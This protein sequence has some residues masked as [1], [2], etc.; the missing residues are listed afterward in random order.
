MLWAIIPA[1]SGSKGLKNKNIQKLGKFE[2]IAHSIKFAKKLKFVDY[3]FVSTD[4]KK[5]KFI[6]EKYGA[7]VPFLRSSKNS[8]D[9]SMEEDILFEIKKNCENCKIKLPDEILWLR[10]TH[11]LR[12][13]NSF[14]NAYKIFKKK[15]STTIIVTKTDPRIFILKKKI[16]YPIVQ[17]FYKKSMIRRQDSP[18]AVK[19]FHGEFFKF[20]HTYKKN[21]LGK[22]I[23]YVIQPSECSVDIDTQDDLAYLNFI[24]KKNN[25]IKKFLHV[26]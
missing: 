18:T 13:L 26:K 24:I 16:L 9:Q 25:L 22:K 3:I 4:S 17:T 20:P 19:M 7:N 15:K 11:P 23:S 5:Y 8:N 14:N 2:L 21:F 1:R 12:C 6:A 10:P